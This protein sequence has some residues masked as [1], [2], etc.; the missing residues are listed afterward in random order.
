MADY[1]TTEIR[2]Y[3]FDAYARL[4]DSFEGA[5]VDDVTLGVI[6]RSTHHHFPG[7]PKKHVASNVRRWLL[8]PAKFTPFID[9]VAM[10]RAANFDWGV[11][12]TLSDDERALLFVRLAKMIDP[13]SIGFDRE[14]LAFSGMTWAERVTTPRRVA[15]ESGT[16]RERDTVS[17]GI[18]RVSERAVA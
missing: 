6:A 13:Y 16:K 8:N 12:A 15:W 14:L 9:E 5:A 2:E 7:I 3:V 1:S 18:R 10:K 4:G 17:N 11:F